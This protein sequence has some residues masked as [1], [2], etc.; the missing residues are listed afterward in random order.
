[1]AQYADP[2]NTLLIE[3]SKGDVVIEL[4]PDL[5]PNHVAR[6]KELA[7]EKL[8]DGI[9][10]HRVI[11]GFMAQVGCPRGN[12]TGGSDKPDLKAEFSDEK[13]VRGTVSAARSS[14]PDSANSQ[15]FICFDEAPWLNRQY[16]VW[17]KVTEG[18]DIVDQLEKGEPVRN[19]DKIVSMRV[20]ADVA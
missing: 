18:M 19:P 2:E 8:Y 11:D 14:N 9:V 5:A 17:G 3:T 10:F 1:M 7:R 13:H 4:R 12:G 15:F 16:S 20:A 6:I